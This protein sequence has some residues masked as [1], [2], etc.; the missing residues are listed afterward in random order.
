MGK[1]GAVLL[2]I[3][4]I[5]LGVTACGRAT[6]EQ[7]NQA[8]GITP[9][10]TPSQAD[11][12]TSTAAAQATEE[13]RLAAQASPSGAAT[14]AVGDVTRGRTQ[15]QTNCMGCHGP[16]SQIGPKLLE[17]GG[18]GVDLTLE[19]LQ[20]VVREGEG[21]PVPPGPYPQSRVA[22]SA[23]RDLYAYIQSEANK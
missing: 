23:I 9:T 11:L 19:R 5:A 18:V 12:A 10:P 7:I 2:M 6:E 21:H 22:D 20:A 3:V 15:F 8:L 1:R 13:A 17:P 14:V 4:V 16:F